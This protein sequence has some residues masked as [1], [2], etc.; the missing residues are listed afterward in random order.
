MLTELAEDADYLS[1]HRYARNFRRDSRTFLA[2]GLA[3]DRQIE[4]LNQLCLEVQRRTGS[5]KRMYLSVDEWNVWY[6]DLSPFGWGRR[7]PHL[8]EETY[9][10]EDALVVAGF[11]NS[12]IRHADVVKIANLAQIVNVIAPI[13]TRGDDLLL[14]STY[15]AFRMFSTRR[16]G[17]AVRVHATGPTYGHRKYGQ[18]PFIDSSAILGDDRL[19]L[20]VVNRSLD[21]AAPIQ[22]ELSGRAI[23]GVAD[24][25]LLSGPGAKAR[26]TFAAPDV[27]VPRPCNALQT[28]GS[29][30]E[31]QLPPLSLLAATITLSSWPA[32]PASSSYDCRAKSR[33]RRAKRG[34]VPCLSAGARE[35][36]VHSPGLMNRF[37]R[38]GAGRLSSCRLS[39]RTRPR[40]ICS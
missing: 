21:S 38:R 14:Q 11:L 13:R 8:L 7:A 2:F 5:A 6:R 34:K 1:V 29:S 16:D 35:L 28:S 24:A 18:V 23:T 27:V 33:V 26:N 40:S 12:F 25:D 36:R 10:L 30:A 17:V 32:W 3:M 31:A 15:H 22:I 4:E 39:E 19:H 37:C 20:F 9:N